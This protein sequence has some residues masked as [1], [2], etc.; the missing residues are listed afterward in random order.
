MAVLAFEAQ[1]ELQIAA[2]HDKNTA[3]DGEF[4]RME[5]CFANIVRLEAHDDAMTRRAFQGDGLAHDGID[6]DLWDD[7][8]WPALVG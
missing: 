8:C 6:G 4:S 3:I 2:R 5:I 1:H 7:S